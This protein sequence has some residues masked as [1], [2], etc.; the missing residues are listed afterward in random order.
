MAGVEELRRKGAVEVRS[1]KRELLFLYRLCII[2]EDPETKKQV[3]LSESISS[4]MLRVPEKDRKEFPALQIVENNKEIR[5][6][7]QVSGS[8]AVKEQLTSIP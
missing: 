3:G 7:L 6:C 4:Q 8:Q 1:W 5:V 2:R